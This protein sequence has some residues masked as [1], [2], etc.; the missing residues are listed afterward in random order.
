MNIYY[1][2]LKRS[3]SACIA[4]IFLIHF[5]FLLLYSLDAIIFDD[6]SFWQSYLFYTSCLIRGDIGFASLINEDTVTNSLAQNLPATLELFL[7]SFIFALMIGVPLGLFSGIKDGKVPQFI[8]KTLCLIINASPI[9][10]VSILTLFIFLAKTME[11]ALPNINPNVTLPFHSGFFIIDI[12]FAPQDARSSLI[13][14]KL[15][16]FVLPLFV[17]SLYNTILIISCMAEST[18][19]IIKQNYIKMA[20]IRDE[21]YLSIVF[22]HII[23]N[24][25][26]HVITTL[27]LHLSLLFS[28]VITVEILFNLPGMGIWIYHAFQKNDI[29]I[30]VVG[31]L[32]LSTLVAI[33]NLIGHFISMLL[34]PLKYKGNYVS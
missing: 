32:T 9:T 2:L 25:I 26:P 15:L 5:G 16:Q 10:W 18:K 19:N 11:L 12:W 8:I 4:I 27:M 28:L 33:I 1:Y 22:R 3:L 21:S 13:I 17:L 6:R 24:T 31:V 20:S 14:N 29:L 34:V 30:A 23:P 7:F